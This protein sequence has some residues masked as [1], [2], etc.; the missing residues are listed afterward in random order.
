MASKAK[1]DL[2]NEVHFFNV[3]VPNWPYERWEL[4]VST[5][6]HADIEKNASPMHNI[7]GSVGPVFPSFLN[8]FS[9][10]LDIYNNCTSTEILN[11][12]T[13]MLNDSL[14][15]LGKAYKCFEK[16]QLVQAGSVAEKTKIEAQDEF[17]FL[18][19]MEYFADEEYFQTVVRKDVIRIYVKDP[20][21][22]D[23]LPIECQNHSGTMEFLDVALRSKFMELFIEIF[24]VR[25]PPG[26]RRVTTEDKT[27]CGSGIA[28][29]LHL[30]CEKF[31]LNIDI[32]LCLCLPIRANDF[33]GA[34]SIPE[35]VN[36]Q[37]TDYLNSQTL[38]FGYIDNIMEQS[39][40]KLF[41]ILGKSDSFHEAIS[42]RITA[43]YL[44]LSYFQSFPPEDGRIKAYCTAKCILSAFLP[45]LSKIF[46]CKRCCH[47]LVR[48]YHI[49]NI[50]LFMLKN[51]NED[52]HWKEHKVPLR[53]LEIFSIL[54]Q[55]MINDDESSYDAAVSIYCFPGTLYLDNVSNLSPYYNTEGGQKFF[56]TPDSHKPMYELSSSPVY[57][58]HL[59]TGNDEADSLLKE[60]FEKLNNKPWNSKQLLL[61]LFNLITKINEIAH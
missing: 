48:T 59:S 13:T 18:V 17:D 28:S 22:I 12:V 29:T 14:C 23:C 10:Q 58:Q 20:T 41:A 24:D 27:P 9:H 49:K 40:L 16:C 38:L 43:P 26:W 25:L 6:G 7:P 4:S 35:D 31:N 51:Y 52:I 15:E 57:K 1:P 32:D 34:L 50:F 55:C 53:V 56:F 3:R 44:E 11:Q 54:E 45:K 60:W 8:S 2:E 33:K 19:V 37:F 47:K 42:A 36:P 5:E 46:G 39:S 30:V 61:D 21:A